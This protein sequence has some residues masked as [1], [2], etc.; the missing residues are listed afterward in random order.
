MATSLTWPFLRG[1][2]LGQPWK[3]HPNIPKLSEYWIWQLQWG[4]PMSMS[5]SK[6]QNYWQIVRSECQTK[7]IVLSFDVIAWPWCTSMAAPE[8]CCKNGFIMTVQTI[9]PVHQLLTY[10][11]PGLVL[12][13]Y[14][15][16]FFMCISWFFQVCFVFYSCVFL[17]LLICS[18]VMNYLIEKIC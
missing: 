11:P 6:L 16:V 8:Q 14:L 9:E 2:K 18:D 17:Y 13:I 15:H 1:Q 3:T 12:N 7:C 10:R 5:A 4:N